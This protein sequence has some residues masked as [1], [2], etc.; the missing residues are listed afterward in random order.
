MIL[1]PGF[2]QIFFGR[3]QTDGVHPLSLFD[4]FTFN[5]GDGKCDLGS[6]QRENNRGGKRLKGGERGKKWRDSLGGERERT[7]GI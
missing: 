1:N 3:L 6:R 4:H 7:A 5:C 2:S